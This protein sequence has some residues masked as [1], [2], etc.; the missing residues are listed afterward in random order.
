S[1]ET[2]AWLKELFQF[3][4]SKAQ[5]LKKE[6]SFE[7]GK[8]EQGAEVEGNEAAFSEFLEEMVA[9]AKKDNMPLPL[10]V[11]G[12]TGTKV[13]ERRNVGNF[14]NHFRKAGE[15]PPQIQVPKLVDA[16]N[17]YGVWLKAHNVDYLTDEGVRWHAQLGIHAANIA[18]EFGVGETLQILAICKEFGFKQETEEFLS[19]AYESRKWEKWMMPNSTATDTEKA[20]ISGHYV[21]STPSF[22][23]LKER[24]KEK[25]LPHNIDLDQ[26]L[27]EKLKQLI[28][29]YLFNFN[30][31]Q[32]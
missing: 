23:E 28:Y 31:V 2:V 8:E 21:F 13:L 27:K 18:P 11:V 6:V 32:S 16:C 1:Q 30:L 7:F 29:R 12:Q 9:F 26:C 4:H 3:C 10:F 17:R 25:C 20:I 24:L 14:E 22:R 15:I 19:L 5:E